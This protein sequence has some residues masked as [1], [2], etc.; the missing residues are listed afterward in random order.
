MAAWAAAERGHDIRIL[1][2]AGRSAA[3]A[4]VRQGQL[5]AGV[6]LL[7][8]H[9]NIGSIKDGGRVVE[10][11]LAGRDTLSVEQ[12]WVD[13][14]R[15]KYGYALNEEPSFLKYNEPRFEYDGNKAVADLSHL[16]EDCIE[17]DPFE[18]DAEAISLLVADESIDRI[19]STVP[20]NSLH[21]AADDYY[22]ADLYVYNSEAGDR[23]EAWVWYLPLPAV[24]VYRC[25]AA[26]GR[27]TAEYGPARSP[28]FPSPGLRLVRQP[29]GLSKAAVA[30][31]DAMEADGRVLF[32][33][34]YGRWDKNVEQHDVYE[35]V[36]NWLS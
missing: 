10:Y 21:P 36:A 4:R 1:D 15:K 13:Y 22:A 19:I 33:G 28:S 24:S 14:Q 9:C 32:A 2:G 8:D 26:F 12:L 20:L 25:S 23:D 34:R 18:A 16:L 11:V 7:H 5:N 27:F 6:F 31:R 35:A 3:S 29:L 17:E 30:W